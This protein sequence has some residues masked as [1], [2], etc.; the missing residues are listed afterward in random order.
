[1]RFLC[2]SVASGLKR[3]PTQSEKDTQETTLLFGSYS[4]TPQDP[5]NKFVGPEKLYHYAVHYNSTRYEISGNTEPGQNIVSLSFDSVSSFKS[6]Y[7]AVHTYKVKFVDTVVIN[8]FIERW[9]EAHPNYSYY[10]ATCQDFVRDFLA[11]VFDIKIQT[12]S[13]ILMEY[14]NYV[15]KVSFYMFG[16]LICL[17]VAYFVLYFLALRADRVEKGDSEFFLLL[18]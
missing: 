15:L 6:D 8:K 16:A 12:Q 9:Q 3:F 2:G 5:F 11:E 13:D 18:L 17:V 14:A 1:M 10:Q 4:I 7:N